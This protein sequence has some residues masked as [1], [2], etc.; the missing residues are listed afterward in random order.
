MAARCEIDLSPGSRKLPDSRSARVSFVS[1][2]VSIFLC[3]NRR[4]ED[5]TL[6]VCGIYEP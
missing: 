3:N 1:D 6:T 5:L 2:T 4:S